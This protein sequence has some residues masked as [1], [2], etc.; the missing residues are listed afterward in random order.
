L[1]D[2]VKLRRPARDDSVLDLQVLAATEVVVRR[3]DQQDEVAFRLEA[4]LKPVAVILDAPDHPD[5]RGRM[6]PDAGS[7]VVQ[8]HV[9]ADDWQLHGPARLRKP[10]DRLLELPV[11]LRAVRVRE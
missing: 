3:P 7:F 2:Q 8:A 10:G 1:A 11:D 6:N 9:A 5:D 4:G